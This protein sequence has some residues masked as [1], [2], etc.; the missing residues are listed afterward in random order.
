MSS[1]VVVTYKDTGLP[2]FTQRSLYHL[3]FAL[4]AYV[5]AQGITIGKGIPKSYVFLCSWSNSYG[6]R[7]MKMSNNAKVFLMLFCA[8]SIALS[9]PLLPQVPPALAYGCTGTG[10]NDKD[11][12]QTGCD[13]NAVTINIIYPASSRV[14]LRASPGCETEWARTG[15][16]DS[17]QRSFYANATLKNYYY[18]ASPGPIAWMQNVYSHQRYV[19]NINTVTLQACGGVSTSQ[20]NYPINS[21]CTP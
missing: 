3:G 15:N 9:F 8:V 4:V 17:L 19:T 2:S 16:I 13:L 7:K 5:T 14:D 20:N 6:D 11:P 10:C 1:S 12:N 18:V 21:P